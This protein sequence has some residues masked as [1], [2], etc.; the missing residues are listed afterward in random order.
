[1]TTVT[2]EWQEYEVDQGPDQE[3]EDSDQSREETL[4]DGWGPD[5]QAAYLPMGRTYL[6]ESH[7][8]RQR[9]SWNSKAG[10]KNQVW[11]RIAKKSGKNPKE[12]LWQLRLKSQN[13]RELFQ[14]GDEEFLPTWQTMT[15]SKK[16]NYA[17]RH[18]NRLVKRDVSRHTNGAWSPMGK[19][20]AGGAMEEEQEDTEEE[21]K[22]M[23][24][25]GYPPHEDIA[26]R[27][28]D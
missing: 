15:E 19:R 22:A 17:P 16:S 24:M 21:D 25:P 4:Q 2:A 7:L 3:I 10:G 13:K 27:Y 1:M 8:L 11:L 20:M 6:P 9:R 26:W 14:Q 28:F 23:E 5:N 12:N 18:M